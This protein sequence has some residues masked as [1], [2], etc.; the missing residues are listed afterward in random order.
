LKDQ[1]KKYDFFEGISDKVM[2]REKYDPKINKYGVKCGSS[3]EDWEGAGWI[4]KWD[5]YGWVQWYCE[6][7]SGR[8]CKD[9][10]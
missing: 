3:L 4:T 9:D 10:I 5:P 8:R 1:H 2:T 7:Y 6:F